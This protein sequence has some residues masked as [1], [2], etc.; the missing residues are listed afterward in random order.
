MVYLS[1]GIDHQGLAD[2][3][4]DDTLRVIIEL[5][6]VEEAG[7]VTL[8]SAHPVVGDSLT[9][10]L[11]DPDGLVSYNPPRWHW[12]QSE[13]LP[14]PAWDDISRARS[15]V[16]TPSTKD[17]G[18]LLRATVTYGDGHGSNKSAASE[19]T[20]AVATSRSTANS[21]AAADFDGD[22]ATDF[23]DFF[24]FAEHF[25]SSDTRF[26]LDDSGAV[27]FADFFLFAE[28][29]APPAR[30]KLVAMA[31]E[32]IGLPDSSQLQQNAPNPFNSQTVLSYFLHAPGP[33]R[34]EV[35]ALTGQ[36]V[37]VLHRGPQQAGYHRLHWDARDDAG[38]PVASG[39]YLYRL[40]T[41]E[42][43][44]TRK[45]MLLR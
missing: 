21:V 7:T 14:T 40:V 32:L 20:A 25:G 22:G 30:A 1:D 17:E 19:P 11:S 37:A 41:D 10:S 3:S 8:S 15:N 42:G 34:L 44:L 26:D 27:D 35:F 38:R 9:A 2:P 28:H 36:R 39:M 16:Y 23:T 45:L 12:Q 31:Q 13:D 43:I 4:V 6:N 24:L 18:R 5:I 33:A 29:F